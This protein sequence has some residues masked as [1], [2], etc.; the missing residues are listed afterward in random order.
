MEITI[1]QFNSDFKSLNETKSTVQTS[2]AVFPKLYY[3]LN[4]HF[5]FYLELISYD[6]KWFWIFDIKISHYSMYTASQ[7]TNGNGLTGPNMARV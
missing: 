4:Y 5:N 7:G 6:E 1:I 3:V 2:K